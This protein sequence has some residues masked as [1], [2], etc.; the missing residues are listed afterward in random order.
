MTLFASI[1]GEFHVLL[2]ALVLFIVLPLLALPR[3]RSGSSVLVAGMSF[4]I[5]VVGIM[6]YF[7]LVRYALLFLVALIAM[8][9]AR[10][11]TPRGQSSEADDK[12]RGGLWD[13]FEQP[14]TTLSRLWHQGR[15]HLKGK[16]WTLLE[17]YGWIGLILLVISILWALV[18]GSWP[19]LH[20]ADPG[21]PGG[22]AN[23]L[24]IASITS[25]AGVYASGTA[26]LGLAALGAAMATAFFLPSMDVLRFLYPLAD[27]FTVIVVGALAHQVTRSARIT[28]VI[29]FITSAS[30]IAYVGFPINFESPIMVHWALVLVLA[31][32]AEAIAWVKTS[33]AWHAGVSAM[34]FLAGVLMGPPEALVGLAMASVLV[35]GSTRRARL[36]LGGAIF[37]LIMGSIPILLGLLAGHPLSPNGWLV[38]P[39]PYLKPIW[40][41]PTNS[42]YLVTW[43]GLG[44]A[45]ARFRYPGDP[46]RRRLAWAIGGTALVAGALGWIPLVGTT[47]LWSDFLG[48]LV[49]LA[50]I[51]LIVELVLARSHAHWI[52]AVGALLVAVLMP[53]TPLALARYE[54]IFAG[55]TTLHIE[56][57]FPPYQ[58]TVISPG[59][60][61]S[62]VLGRGWHEELSTFVAT[63][64]LKEAQNPRFT[65]AQDKKHPILSP[66]IFLYVEPSI[67]PYGPTV[68][69][70]DLALRT[71]SGSPSAESFLTEEAHAYFWAQAYHQSH[72]KTSQFSVQSTH[73]M[74]L[75]IRQ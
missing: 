56:E 26:P 47:L 44:I 61:Y 52:V 62:E 13:G 54:P 45:V 28:A 10:R 65:L 25:N 42:A 1:V 40:Y 35:I 58:W 29:M 32:L 53:S 8:V 21:T 68:T 33:H 55:R 37:V 11:F 60:Q 31:G 23:L 24:R 12:K 73:L 75:W 46:V 27:L 70:Q 36:V 19:W 63:Y 66:N 20:Q 69:K 17:D 18:V 74:V 6:A 49:L 34:A 7:S 51:D 16:L 5:I 15:L 4:W 57:A 3:I 64:T 43:F 38:A 41:D 39:F 14:N 9:L 67:Y 71:S 50:G 30:T 2:A 72:P 22:Y 59:N 48:L